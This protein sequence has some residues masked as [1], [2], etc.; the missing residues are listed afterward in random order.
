MTVPKTVLLSGSHLQRDV[1]L[2][3]LRIQV[4]P[5]CAALKRCLD[6]RNPNK[7]RSQP[8]KI[9][10]IYIHLYV[11]YSESSPN[12]YTESITSNW[13]LKNRGFEG[14]VRFRCNKEVPFEKIASTRRHGLTLRIS[15]FSNTPQDA[16]TNSVILRI[17]RNR[18]EL[19]KV[20]GGH[21]FVL[22]ATNWTLDFP[23]L[24]P[25]DEQ[26]VI[27]RRWITGPAYTSIDYGRWAM[28]SQGPP[29]FW[30]YLFTLQKSFPPQECVTLNPLHPNGR[31]KE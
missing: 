31:T 11:I 27:T 13:K 8:K 18:L 23:D 19:R 28:N 12:R 7:M 20:L 3:K 5:G 16:Q 26:K 24:K 29:V 21:F 15:K 10:Y 9:D 17:S 30:I 2:V 1:W 25:W 14:H 6:Q 22:N 4:T